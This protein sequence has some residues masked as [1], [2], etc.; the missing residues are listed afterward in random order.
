MA[1]V[2][3]YMNECQLATNDSSDV[4]MKTDHVVMCVQNCVADSLELIWVLIVSNRPS[5]FVIRLVMA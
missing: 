4:S 2:W 1:T 5:D 3:R